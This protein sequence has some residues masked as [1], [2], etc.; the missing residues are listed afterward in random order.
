MKFMPDRITSDFEPALITVVTNVVS[1]LLEYFNNHWIKKVKFS[2]WNASDLNI[3]TNNHVEGE[4]FS[5]AFSK[6]N[7]RPFS[8]SE[9]NNRFNK[10]MVR[11][12]PN[13]WAFIECLMKEDIVFQQQLL[14]AK[15]GGQK[16]KAKK[17]LSMQ[18][19]IDTLRTRFGDNEIDR[20]EYLE[21][22]SLLVA[23]KK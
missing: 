12:H 3:R 15:A 14:K 2:L 17:T 20:K 13:I 23:I 11:S 5:S 19:Q 16:V 7:H 21:G 10:R 22:L 1:Y 8:Q 4:R 9:W 18:K 6:S